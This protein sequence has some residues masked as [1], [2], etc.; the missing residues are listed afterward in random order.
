[1]QKLNTIWW[2][3]I[4]LRMIIVLRTKLFEESITFIKNETIRAL[5]GFCI[6]K[7]Y[8]MKTKQTFSCGRDLKTNFKTGSNLL[9]LDGL[10]ACVFYERGKIRFHIC[11]QKI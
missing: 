10:I 2:L 8:A 11:L 1:M 6:F 4:C 9:F 3:P 7:K 5:I